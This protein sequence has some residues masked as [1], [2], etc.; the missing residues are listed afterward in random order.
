[1]KSKQRKAMEFK[2]TPNTAVFIC[3][4]VERGA[5]VLYVSHDGDGDWQFLCGATHD[6]EADEKP[7][8][9]CLKEVVEKDPSL[10][11]LAGMFTNHHAERA[12]KSNYWS[13]TDVGE[14]FIQRSVRDVGWSVQLIPAGEAPNEPAFAYTVGLHKSYG[15]PELI[16]F[17]LD[18]QVMHEVLN[19]LGERIK[20]G[21]ALTARGQVADVLVGQDVRLREVLTE[22]S[23]RAYVGYARWFNGGSTFRLLQV[24]WP[25]KDGRFPGDAGAAVFLAGL[26]PVLS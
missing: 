24:L 6:D 23:F 13:V 19:N 10:N 7:M 11:Q 1:L 16:I 9:V 17:G 20:A 21:K 3:G 5:P 26:Q 12:S 8:L 25:D 15:H 14:E 2:E 18:H 4:H 22:E